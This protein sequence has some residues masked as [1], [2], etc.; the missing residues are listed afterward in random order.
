M[1]KRSLLR[2]EEDQ[3]DAAFCLK[4]IMAR[5]AKKANRAQARWLFE[6]EKVALASQVDPYNEFVF[7]QHHADSEGTE[8]DEDRE[9]VTPCDDLMPHRCGWLIGLLAILGL[10]C[11]FKPFYSMAVVQL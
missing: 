10:A 1:R 11:I 5:N 8:N 3:G 2:T 9:K 7:E 4:T 6:P